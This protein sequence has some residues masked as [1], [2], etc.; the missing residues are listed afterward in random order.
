MPAVGRSHGRTQPSAAPTTHARVQVLAPRSQVAGRHPRRT[1]H[2]G[3]PA[4]CQH[5]GVRRLLFI[6][7]EHSTEKQ[8]KKF[9]FLVF[10]HKIIPSINIPAFN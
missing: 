8:N 5:G 6:R 1:A 10:I 7:S 2:E 4:G 9:L 3:E